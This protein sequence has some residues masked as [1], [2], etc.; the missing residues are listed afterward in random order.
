MIKKY[1]L[2]K[3]WN[4]NNT[5]CKYWKVKKKQDDNEVQL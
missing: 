5:R 4:M 3:V 1:N 2:V